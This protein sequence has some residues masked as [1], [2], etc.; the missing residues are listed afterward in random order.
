ML[1]Q[2]AQGPLLVVS[3]DVDIASKSELISAS[4][5]ALQPPRP[6]HLDLGDVEFID[7][8]GLGALVWIKRSADDAGAS[9]VVVRAS[10]PVERLLDLTAMRDVFMSEAL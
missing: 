7:S 8:T 1:R 6:L 4:I 5:H 10:K 3:G 9:L 2:D